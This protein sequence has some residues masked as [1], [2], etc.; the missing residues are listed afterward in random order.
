M[1][2]LLFGGTFDPP[3]TGHIS[4]LENAIKL[5]KPNKVVVMPAGIPPHKEASTTPGNLRMEMCR[6][7]LP[8]F[9]NIEISDIE[10]KRQGS[11]YTWYSLQELEKQYPGSTFYLCIGSDMLLYFEKWHRYKEILQKVILVG[12]DRQE[13]DIPL[14]RAAAQELHR[15]GGTV[16]FTGG[17]IEEVSSTWLR[18]AIGN[19]EDV[20]AFIP[21]ETM[22]VIVENNLYGNN[23]KK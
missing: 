14:T 6:C 11:S 12:Q 23:S 4:L 7:F 22:Q 5:V 17:H 15:Q 1:K 10:I 16:L 13:T 8:C 20:S 19:K 21:E 9:A 2:L 3:H 18:Q